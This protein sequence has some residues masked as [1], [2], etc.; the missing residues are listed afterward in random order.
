[1][2][3]NPKFYPLFQQPHHTIWAKLSSHTSLADS[4]VCFQ[5]SVGLW[6]RL[7][8]P[9]SARAAPGRWHL[10]VRLRCHGQHGTDHSYSDVHFPSE[11]NSTQ[12]SCRQIISIHWINSQLSRLSQIHLLIYSSQCVNISQNY[13]TH[14]VRF[15]FDSVFPLW[16]KVYS[17]SHEHIQ[18]MKILVHQRRIKSK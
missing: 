15:L 10:M 18:Y 13:S 3:E 5:F 16:P 2:A 14:S 8:H 6:L 11:R 9:S 17:M 7:L 1:M 4:K 12:I